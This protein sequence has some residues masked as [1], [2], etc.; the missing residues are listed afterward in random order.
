MDRRHLLGALVAAPAAF[1]LPV[2]ARAVRT[3]PDEALDAVF[4]STAPTALGGA[5]VTRTGPG[6]S[7]VRGVRRAGGDQPVTLEDRWHIGS[8]TKA[9]TAAVFARLV[10]AGRADW[11]MTVAGAF[12]QLAID[13]S[14]RATPLTA[15]MRH[16]SG[17]ADADVIGIDWL[18]VARGDPRSLPAQRAAIAARALGRPPSGTPGGF[19]YSNA[20][21][22]IVGAAIEAITGQAWEDVTRAQLFQP[23]GL[24]GAGF[25]P[26]PDPNA[27][28]H[29]APGGPLL[30][31]DPSTPGADN[32]AALGP[33]GTAHMTLADNG[34]W[35]QAM[36]GGG[37]E[38]WLGA[39][40]LARLT[41]TTETSP[42]YAL[43][44]ITRPAPAGGGLGRTIGHEGSNTLWHAVVMAAPDRGLGFI[45]CSNDAANGAAACRQ[46]VQ[47]LMA[48]ASAA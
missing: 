16:R 13:P 20:G 33:A 31:M 39:D 4:A 24:S 23:L 32:P 6:W 30:P 34:R 18:G 37:P 14:W 41:T 27:W 35:V 47:G 29:R 5:M 42:A 8:N 9:M 17:L 46:L 1:A 3:G 15:L 10:E 12:P 22:I 2:R 25:G 28:G 26:P 43:G 45:A 44:W 48:V 36:L 19:A 11:D 7:G 21:Y 40:S 38:G